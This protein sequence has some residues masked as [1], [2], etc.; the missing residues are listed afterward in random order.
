MVLLEKDIIQII[1]QRM[2]ASGSSSVPA[3]EILDYMYGPA[4]PDSHSEFSE[5]VKTLDERTKAVYTACRRKHGYKKLK[6]PSSQSL[7]NCHGLWTEYLF[8]AISWNTLSEF[9]KHSKSGKYY[10]YVK[11]PNRKDTDKASDSASV[12]WTNLLGE[13]ASNRIQV[14]KD[15]LDESA[16]RKAR[17]KITVKLESS[18]PDAVILCLNSSD[19]S[20]L[21]DPTKAID[22]L[23][24]KTQEELDSIFEKCKGKVVDASQIISFLSVKTSTRPDRRYQFILEG[25]S[26]KGLYA[27]A[28]D[29]DNDL[30]YG[31]LM[32]NRFFAFTLQEKKDAD[33]T[34]L[35]GLIMFASLFNEAVGPAYAIDKLYDCSA[36][37]DVAEKIQEIIDLPRY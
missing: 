26:T 23:S 37:S 35:D 33:H 9:N 6:I 32:K 21:L 3:K 36:L 20:G 1:K 15:M 4:L 30:K 5:I 17:E 22:N 14:K 28:C 18:N 11:L 34:A 16:T 24:L 31:A 7:G 25:N 2:K 19:C 29:P 10:I 8:D 12:F 13:E 27:I